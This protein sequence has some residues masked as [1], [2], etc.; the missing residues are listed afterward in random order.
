MADDKSNFRNAC[1]WCEPAVRGS[2]I[3]TWLTDWPLLG[4][5]DI[6][7]WYGKI[8]QRRAAGNACYTVV[9][10]SERRIFVIDQNANV[11]KW[12]L[13]GTFDDPVFVELTNAAD[14]PV[15]ADAVKFVQI[16][17]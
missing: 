17:E 1:Y 2:N 10:R 9:T 6:S 7:I 15:I 4:R 8:P 3:A 5:Y 16:R 11:G 14:G 12:N 13:L